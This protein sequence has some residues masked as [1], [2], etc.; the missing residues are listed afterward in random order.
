MG[1]YVR[2]HRR[3]LL[4][5]AVLTVGSITFLALRVDLDEALEQLTAVRLEWALPGLLAFTL[6]KTI[7]AY[8]W[9]V[10]LWH[11]RELHAGDLLSVF[12]VSNLANA[13]M[14]LRAGDV[15][16]VEL[17]RRRF[18]IPRPELTSSVFLVESVLDGV[19]FVALLVP[20][21]LLLDPSVLRTPM[22]ALIGAGVL[23]VFAAS[24]L[25]ARLDVASSV[26]RSRL[27]RPLPAP[28]RARLAAVIPSFVNGM[29][30]LRSGRPVTIAIAISIVAWM[31]EVSVYWMMG[32]AFGLELSLS[33]A[34]LVMIAAN[35][36]VSLPL[37]PW[38][39]GPYEVAVTEALALMG[40]GLSQA[41]AYAVGSHILLV[42]WISITGLIAMWTL[43]VSPRELITSS[44]GE[45]ESL[46]GRTPGQAGTADTATQPDR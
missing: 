17:T 31:A 46:A 40:F 3:L 9:R 45:G 1:G 35:V 41:G 10:L 19:A 38:D 33:E 32:R 15:L 28:A 18:G 21:L 20:A 4:L 12:L 8:R 29:R 2:R 36:I 22:F 6:S 23:G 5:Q 13:V 11:R 44:E 27:L 37:T 42:I 30:V 7:H 16:R 25:V 26:E 24:L 14:P 34:V 43:Q 39:V